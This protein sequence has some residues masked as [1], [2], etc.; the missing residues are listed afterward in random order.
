MKNMALESYIW[1]CVGNHG[2]VQG[3]HFYLC[4]QATSR[5]HG[6]LGCNTKGGDKGERRK[7]L[8]FH[9]PSRPRR[10]RARQKAWK[11][12]GTW[13]HTGICGSR[14]KRIQLAVS[15]CWPSSRWTR[16]HTHCPKCQSLHTR[17]SPWHG[18]QRA[19]HHTLQRYARRRGHPCSIVIVR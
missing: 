2:L 9:T 4:S 10:V 16:Y 5:A 1:F 19:G 3:S 6:A 18:W 12:W 14:T 13:S 7:S 15:C 11:R 8:G 17:S